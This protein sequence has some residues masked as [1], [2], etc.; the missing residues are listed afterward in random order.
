MIGYIQ[1]V[2]RAL[3]L[4]VSKKVRIGIP[5]VYLV[6]SQ[7]LRNLGF[8]ASFLS[9]NF[10][11]KKKKKRMSEASNYFSAL[12]CP[13]VYYFIVPAIMYLLLIFTLHAV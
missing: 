11:L 3:L 7:Q 4:I 12:S 9:L 2:A 8:C 1:K 6:I 13:F 10:F 5:Q